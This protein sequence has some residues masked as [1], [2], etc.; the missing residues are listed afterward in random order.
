MSID[1]DIPAD[2]LTKAYI[3]IRAER[4]LL[5]ADY[6]E[7]DRNLSQQLD[8][9][10]KALLDYCDAHNVESVK[11]T[12]GLFFRSAKTKYWTGD[13]ESMYAFIK[14]HDMPEFL[15]R[16]LNQTNVKQFLEENPD[17]MPKGLN[18]TTDHV[19]TVRKK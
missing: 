12:E 19:I 3:N 6:K 7:K 8:T 1:E 11:T 15:D 16:R 9:L 17:V 18:I 13:W 2:K 10:K 5:S 14:E 4:A